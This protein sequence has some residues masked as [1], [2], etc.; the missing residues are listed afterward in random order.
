MAGE[1]ASPQAS[2]PG[3]EHEG[4]E[5]DVSVAHVARVYNYWLGGKDNF[6]AD[7]EAGDETIAAYPAIRMSARA[8]RAFLA[9][10]VRYLA[11]DE[12][13]RQY[14]DIG[15]G[16]PT[17][18]NTHEVAQSVAPESRIVYVDNDP[19]VLSHARALLTSTP[20]G[21]TAYLDADVRNP[22]KIIAQAQETLDFSQPMAIMLIAILHYVPDLNEAK[23]IV[24]RLVSAVAP[25]SFL[26][27]SHAASDIAAEEMVEFIKRMNEHL[28]EG[29]TH[30]ARPH[31]VVVS[32]FDGLELVEPGVV[33]VADW[34]PGSDLKPPKPTSMWGG[35]ARKS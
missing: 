17:A 19:M 33:W 4:P 26:V 11:E 30:I 24:H 32:L 34:R 9:R 7:R 10:T 23:Q 3:D 13:I 31:D 5:F 22:D 1:G 15:T 29:E 8:N 28:R 2:S 21:A 6:A 27:I 35:V 14:L 16:L 20:E 18:N 12:G 25:G